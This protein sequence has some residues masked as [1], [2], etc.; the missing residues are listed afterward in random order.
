MEYATI[1]TRVFNLVAAGEVN[2][3]PAVSILGSMIKSH[4]YYASV[5]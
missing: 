3:E 1:S 5:N 4:D 2:G